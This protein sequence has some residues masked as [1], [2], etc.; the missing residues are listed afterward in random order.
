[1]DCLQTDAPVR[2]FVDGEEDSVLL[3]LEDFKHPKN[4]DFT[5]GK[6]SIKSEGVINLFS[7]VQEGF[8][9]FDPQFLEEV[10]NMREKTS[11]WKC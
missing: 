6:Y 7:D 4:N 1:M 2:C 5:V 10:A 3:Y 9:L 8:S 11:R